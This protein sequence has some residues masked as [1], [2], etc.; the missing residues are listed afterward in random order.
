M[1]KIK[2]LSKILG[3]LLIFMLTCL[4]FSAMESKDNNNQPSEN[5]NKININ[6]NSLKKINS[7]K[8]SDETL[9][10]TMK[11]IDD[12]QF[13]NMNKININKNSLK[14]LNKI[15]NIDNKSLENRIS[16]LDIC[17]SQIKDLM[18]KIISLNAKYID[19]IFSIKKVLIENFI[20]KIN[21]I[22]N[23]F[24]SSPNY[25]GNYIIDKKLINNLI[26]NLKNDIYNNLPKDKISLLNEYFYKIKNLINKVKMF[27]INNYAKDDITKKPVNEL[28]KKILEKLYKNK[29]KLLNSFFSPIENIINKIKALNKYCTFNEDYMEEPIKNIIDICS[30]T[31]DKDIQ[32]LKNFLESNI[33]N[34]HKDEIS[35]LVKYSNQI[36]NHINYIISFNNI[37]IKSLNNELNIKPKNLTVKNSN[38]LVKTEEKEDFLKYEDISIEDEISLFEDMIKIKIKIFEPDP[39][40]TY[41][42]ELFK[43]ETKLGQRY[44]ELKEYYPKRYLNCLKKII[45]Y[46]NMNRDEFIERYGKEI[47]KLFFKTYELEKLNR[48]SY[49]ADYQLKN[50]QYD[51]IKTLEDKIKSFNNL[52]LKHLPNMES[53]LDNDVLNKVLTGTGLTY[54][55][56][57]SETL[58][59]IIDYFKKNRDNFI[60]KYGV[61]LEEMIFKIISHNMDFLKKNRDNFIK[62]YDINEN[63]EK[64]VFKIIFHNINSLNNENFWRKVDKKY[65]IC[66]NIIKII[67]NI[68]ENNKNEIDETLKNT[69]KNKNFNK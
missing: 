13:K 3:I 50:E 67:S 9:E 18:N 40:L 29:I 2:V 25:H 55:N 46:L 32:D 54:G 10:K 33:F 8:T 22:N 14:K 66:K 1:K 64:K 35:L 38:E 30:Y 52:N 31:N 6:K 41:W 60:K 69:K 63:F 20:N 62:K 15:N 28:D 12:D 23:I 48:V 44:L 11:N 42:L 36:Q 51:V 17:F 7:L 39:N 27:Y 68:V 34:E 21:P 45:K 61:E 57:Y 43:K 58:R 49:W 56:Y 65:K 26:N 5:I 16:S 59:N 4:P 53:L 19:D 37:Y 47:E 24:P